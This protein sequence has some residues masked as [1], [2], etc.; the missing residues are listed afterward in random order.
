MKIRQGGAMQGGKRASSSESIEQAIRDTIVRSPAFLLLFPILEKGF[1]QHRSH[2]CWSKA[3]Y[4]PDNKLT[5]SVK[6]HFCFRLDT[7]DL[8]AQTGV[9]CF[10][11]GRIGKQVFF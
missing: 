7:P 4:Y 5:I 6:P 11:G 9:L 8:F 3:R 10:N 2:R 1:A